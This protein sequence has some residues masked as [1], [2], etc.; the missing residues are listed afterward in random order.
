MDTFIASLAQYTGWII[1]G[2]FVIVMT[3]T[4]KIKK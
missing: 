1:L 4:D 2:V 3:I